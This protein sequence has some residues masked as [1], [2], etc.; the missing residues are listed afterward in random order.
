MTYTVTI[1]DYISFTF[2]LHRDQD[3]KWLLSY[4]PKNDDYLFG[5]LKYI[6]VSK[7]LL[8]LWSINIK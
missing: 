8:L 5:K 4:W 7:E 6:K 1:T 2:D 3:N